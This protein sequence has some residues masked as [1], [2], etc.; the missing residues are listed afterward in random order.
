MKLLILFLISFSVF[1]KTPIDM[2]GKEKANSL[3]TIYNQV[4]TYCDNT[5]HHADLVLECKKVKE[6]I[7]AQYYSSTLALVDKKLQ[8]GVAKA[9]GDHAEAQC[10][11]RLQSHFDDE[12]YPYNGSETCSELQAALLV[13]EPPEE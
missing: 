5:G 3:N 7:K 2:V 10:V 4:D 11:K 9:D 1:A 6:V 12:S 8:E 13:H